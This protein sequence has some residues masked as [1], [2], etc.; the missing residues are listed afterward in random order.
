[1]AQ[2]VYRVALRNRCGTL[3]VQTAALGI[4]L[5][6][7]EDSIAPHEEN[8]SLARKIHR[9]VLVCYPSPPCCSHSAVNS[10]ISIRLTCYIVVILC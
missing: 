9:N 3:R 6:R 8:L 1:M 10:S 5:I 7:T 2:K 4:C